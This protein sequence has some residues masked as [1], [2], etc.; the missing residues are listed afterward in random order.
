MV[1]VMIAGLNSIKI[2]LA[3]YGFSR[4]PT[5]RI[6]KRMNCPDCQSPHNKIV[7]RDRS[8]ESSD[9]LRRECENCKKSFTT[10]ELHARYLLKLQTAAQQQADG[11]LAIG[12]PHK[13]GA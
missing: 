9:R 12:H 3:S 13:N 8:S 1:D 7:E 10:Y 6:G 5:N 11:L 4:L 2:G